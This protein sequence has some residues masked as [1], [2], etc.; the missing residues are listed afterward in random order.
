MVV[1]RGRLAPEVGAVVR[2]ARSRHGGR[3]VSGRGAR[4]RR[5]TGGRRGRSRGNVSAGACCNRASRRWRRP[6]DARGQARPCGQRP[7]NAQVVA[8]VSGARPSGWPA[9]PR[10]SGCSTVRTGRFST[11]AARRA[12]SRQPCAVHEEGFRVTIDPSGA[13]QFVRPDGHPLPAA[14]LA[15]DWTGAPLATT[16]KQL[17]AAGIEIDGSTATPAWRG[18]RLDLKWAIGILWRNCLLAALAEC[19]VVRRRLP[20]AMPG[21]VVRRIAPVDHCP[22][23]SPQTAGVKSTNRNKA[24]LSTYRPSDGVRGTGGTPSPS[25]RSGLWGRLGSP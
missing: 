24:Y 11:S 18:E 21:S 17:A 15:P 19:R 20:I 8:R 4:G 1:I 12:Q 5:H 3:P 10:L 13:A 25:R 14:P 6:A 23:L 16:A 2:R 22:G 9:T 7:A